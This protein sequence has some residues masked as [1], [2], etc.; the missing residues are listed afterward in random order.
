MPKRIPDPDVL[1][2]H[3]RTREETVRQVKSLLDLYWDMCGSWCAI[4]SERD[5]A[6]LRRRMMDTR[7]HTI[8]LVCAMMPIPSFNAFDEAEALPDQPKSSAAVH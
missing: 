7:A 3:R 6:E 5:D 4:A 1:R 8:A 2:R